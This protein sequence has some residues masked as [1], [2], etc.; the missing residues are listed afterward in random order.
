VTF[1][2]LGIDTQTNQRVELPQA[3]R[4]QGLYIIGANGTGKTGLIENLILQDIDQGLGVG[5]LDPHGD[6]T[7]AI[8]AKMTKRLDD[9]ILLDIADYN[10]PFGL[11]LFTCNDPTDLKIVSEA[12]N[13][14]MHI[15]KKLWG[16]GGIVVDDAWG[17][18]LEEILRNATMTFLEYSQYEVYTMAEIPLLLEDAAFRNHLVQ[19]L[20]FRYVKNYWLNKYNKLSDKDQLEERRSTLNRLNAFLT[21]PIVENIVGQAKTTVDFPRAMDERKIV[22]VKLYSRMED[23][24]SLIGSMIIAEILDA[25]YSRASIPINKRK[26]F[27]LYAD[28][29]QRFATEDFAILLTEARKFGIAT[30]IAHQTRYQPGITDGIRSVSL[31]AANFVV[32]RITSP[33]A[34]DLAGGFDTTPPPPT[35]EE[36]TRRAIQTSVS[37][38]INWL[39]SGKTHTNPVVNTFISRW[40]MGKIEQVRQGKPDAFHQKDAAQFLDTMNTLCYQ[41]MIYKNPDVLSFDVSFLQLMKYFVNELFG[42]RGYEPG[43]MLDYIDHLL[44]FVPGN[45]FHH[46]TPSW[47][48][49][50]LTSQQNTFIDREHHKKILLKLLERIVKETGLEP[51]VKKAIKDTDLQSRL[52]SHLNILFC[53]EPYTNTGWFFIDVNRLQWEQTEIKPSPFDYRGDILYRETKYVEVLVPGQETT[54]YTLYTLEGEIDRI[55]A[56]P[57]GTIPRQCI[58]GFFSDLLA[59]LRVL[60]VE[61]IEE[62]SGRQEIVMG[63]G[64]QLSSAEMAARIANQLSGLPNYTAR[65]KIGTNVPQNPTKKCL[66]CGHQGNSGAKFCHACGKQLPAPN[67]Y[68]IET[69]PPGQSIGKTALQQRLAAIQTRNRD[70]RYGGY[71]RPRKDVEAEI[72]KRQQQFSGSPA[73]QPQQPPPQQPKRYG[74]QVP[75]QGNCPNC[76]KSNPPGSKFCN[77]CGGKL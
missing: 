56:S 8:L 27:N 45:L 10:F 40:N 44:T 12:S 72:T 51:I 26:Q 28:E 2:V 46:L 62:D 70:P 48:I 18:L 52:Q 49:Q 30:T 19:K 33:D 53:I 68:I 39:L 60:A 5:L 64:I 69:L 31:Q 4:R 23:V 77:Q 43:F 1:S 58:C 14:V 34:D 15:F 6:L 7:N 16:K 76:G 50:L 67:E 20:T 37:N 66:S 55:M 61:P 57:Y 11:N 9:V 24:T 35:P 54:W 63:H 21:Q 41:A 73:L 25:A 17:V 29:F 75:L 74:R 38:P 13:K 71:C 65:V 36:K 3:S 42:G 22:L 59:L 32:F 47:F